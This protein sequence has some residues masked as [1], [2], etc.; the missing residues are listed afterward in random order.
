MPLTKSGCPADFHLQL[1][2]E[3]AQVNL[4]GRWIVVISPEVTAEGA[5]DTK[6]CGRSCRSA[7]EGRRA[8]LKRGGAR[9]A[10]SHAFEY[11]APPF[12]GVRQRPVA[13]PDRLFVSAGERGAG[14]PP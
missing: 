6:D 13:C 14:S 3:L 5:V 11:Y 9:I 1:L 8:S 2:L 10:M 7:G 12:T 4:G